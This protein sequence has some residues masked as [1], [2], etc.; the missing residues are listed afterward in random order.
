MR[1][2]VVL[3]HALVDRPGVNAALN[4]ALAL[5]LVWTFT[6]VGGYALGCLTGVLATRHRPR[7]AQDGAGNSTRALGRVGPQDI[8]AGGTP[9]V[10]GLRNSPPWRCPLVS[11][12]RE[13]QSSTPRPR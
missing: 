7:A 6:A 8:V 3:L 10:R 9:A 12:E 13:W 1:D 2:L 5:I 4:W 11:S